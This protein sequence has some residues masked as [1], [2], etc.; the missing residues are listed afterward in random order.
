MLEPIASPRPSVVALAASVLLLGPVLAGCQREE[1][2]P[3]AAP[4]QPQPQTQAPVVSVAPAPTLDRAGLLQAMDVAASAYAAG[5]E[6]GG[7]DLV[8]RRFALRQV[9]G[10]TGPATPPAADAASGD[11]LARWSWGDRRRT[12]KLT[13]APG[14]WTDS[15]LIAGGA[16]SWEAAEGF[17]LTRPWLRTEGCPGVQG[18]PLAGGPVAPSPQTVGLAAVFDQDG[19]RTG[20]RNG[21]AYE[22]VVRGEG[23]QPPPAPSDGY[24]LV[25]EGRMAAFAD[26]RAIRCRAAGP[27][28]RPVCIGAVRLDRVA[29]EDASGKLLSEWR[30]G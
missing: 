11:G 30:G 24:R 5:G 22:Y 20:R 7:A 13:L 18:D 25:L 23:D 4:S 6:V 16:D 2:A 12:L 1:P 19:P 28:Q 10:C 14:D 9:F 15:A 27:D 17:W 8:G 21:R 29:F 26:G 3:E